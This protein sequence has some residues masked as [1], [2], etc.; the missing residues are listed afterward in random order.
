MDRRTEM[1]EL[2]DQEVAR[3]SGMSA[4]QVASELAE[5]K[6]Y[7]IESNGKIYQFEVQLLENKDDYVH[8]SV[9]VD[10]G[11]LPY[12]IFPLGRIHSEEGSTGPPNLE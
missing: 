7:Q 12:S 2:L 4:E 9:A 5:V 3:W 1:Q 8:A 6:N 10:D 11:R